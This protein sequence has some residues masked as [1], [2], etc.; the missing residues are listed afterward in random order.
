MLIIASLVLTSRQYGVATIWLV[1]TLGSKS[2]LKK[3]TR[4]A[5]LD[6]DLP[7]ACQTITEPELPMA[8]RLQGSLLF[9]VTR[10]FSQQCGYFLTDI[11]SL[12]DKMRGTEH[13]FKEMEVDPEVS[14]ARPEQLNIQ[15][16][17]FFLPELHLNF[18]LAAFGFPSDDSTVS[19]AHSP[20]SLPSSQSSL[21]I[22]DEEEPEQEAVHPEDR[23]GLKGDQVRQALLFRAEAKQH[24]ILRSLEKSLLFLMSLFSTLVMMA[25]F[26]QRCPLIYTAPILQTKVYKMSL[27]KM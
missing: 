7:K 6:V 25:I 27:E 19:S 12:R 22:G 15:E 4:R 14:K 20:R 9:G 3:V 24:S 21:Q 5:I 13:I 18:D 1:A 10:V 16:D 26:I 23:A 17:P 2:N 11:T 8:L